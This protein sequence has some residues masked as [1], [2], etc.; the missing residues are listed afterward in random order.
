M[1]C[2]GN[3]IRLYTLNGA[4]LVDQKI[5]DKADDNVVSCAFYEGAGHEWLERDIL[6]TG[7]RRGV[8]KVIGTEVAESL[9]LTEC[10]S[11]A[12]P[13]AMINLSSS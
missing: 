1:L 7:H 5:G 2:Y 10:R 3:R 8:V 4:L 6:F 12:R 13:Y 11:G 9:L